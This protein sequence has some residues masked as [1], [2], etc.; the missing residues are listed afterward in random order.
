MQIKPQANASYLNAI[1]AQNRPLPQSSD[2]AKSSTSPA[3]AG[4]S[5]V[6]NISSAASELEA[7]MKM[8]EAERMQWIWLHSHG[9]TP[10][11]FAQMSDDEK[12]QLLNQMKE[13][14]KI[15][16]QEKPQQAL[17]TQNDSRAKEELI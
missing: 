6:V 5:S 10:E 13:E 7:F 2:T 15:S 4:S 12:Q 11:E 9:V 17:R 3:G 14:L 1:A 8:S 16:M